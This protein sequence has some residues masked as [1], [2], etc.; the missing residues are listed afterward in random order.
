MFSRHIIPYLITLSAL[1]NLQV[2]TPSS[3]LPNVFLLMSFLTGPFFVLSF[4]FSPV[5]FIFRNSIAIHIQFWLCHLLQ[6]LLLI[7]MILRQGLIRFL[8]KKKNRRS[9]I[10]CHPR[11]VLSMS[12]IHIFLGKNGIDLEKHFYLLYFLWKKCSTIYYEDWKKVLFLKSV[13]Q[14]Q[15][16]CSSSEM[17][18]VNKTIPS[19]L[20]QAGLFIFQW[21]VWGLKT[22]CLC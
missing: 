11:V 2:L 5:V 18:T 6:L 21:L 19:C 15:Q 14:S 22:P 13:D 8:G 4:F 9:W 17:K 7:S 3:S 10:L 16:L 12:C 1:Y 20:D